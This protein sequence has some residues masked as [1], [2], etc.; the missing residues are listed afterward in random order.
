[1][2]I[3]VEDPSTWPASAREY[4]RR[5]Q[6][7][8]FG[9]PELER[10]I[11]ERI[12]AAGGIP[13]AEFMELALYHPEHGYYRTDPTRM[14]LV[15]DYVTSPETHP[16]FGFLIARWLWRAWTRAG[17]PAPWTVLEAGAGTGRLAEQILSSAPSLEKAFAAAL[18]YRI[19]EPD[20]AARALQERT[21]ARWSRKTSW[22][23]D[24]DSA[25]LQ[26]IRGCL[27]SNELFDA[28]PVHR[29]VREGRALRELWIVER[30]GALVEE[31]RPLS[32]PEL[33]RYFRRYGF[34][35]PTG[36]PVEVN[37]AAPAW[38]AAAA[39]SLQRGYL[40]TIDYGGT[41]EELYRK[42]GNTGTLRAFYRHVLSTELFQHIGEQD[43]TA[44][45]DF[46]ALIHAGEAAGLVTREYT[47]QCAFLSRLAW[48]AWQEGRPVSFPRASARLRA[49]QELVDLENLGEI[50]VLVQEKLE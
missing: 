42:P 28:M 25:A 43:L 29:V 31:P 49:L 27:L 19:V 26:P 20:A 5:W 6:R 16:A 41:A 44:D 50:R 14:T 12:R 21:L 10:L 15:G 32:R 46:T 1:V 37:L 24:L 39:R 4:Y 38:I 23:G 40:L 17:K 11:R 7:D 13:F 30:D 18:R 33:R 48:E 45:V 3:R 36:R 9:Q 22:V 34:L 35:P 8:H 47:T 2:E